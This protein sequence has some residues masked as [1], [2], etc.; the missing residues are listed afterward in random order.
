MKKTERREN[1]KRVPVIILFLLLSEFVH[2][3]N[4]TSDI[5]T[6]VRV[7]SF[8]E[9]GNGD[10]VVVTE[11]KGTSCV[12][13]YWLK[14]VDP[15]FNAN[16]SMLIAAYQAKTNIVLTGLTDEIWSGSGG[17]YCHLYSVDYR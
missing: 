9:Y 5:T 10:V 6:I 16:L 4:E 13:G 14:K 2:A 11:K 3:A 1:M 12:S 8:S 7:V 15:G 17:R